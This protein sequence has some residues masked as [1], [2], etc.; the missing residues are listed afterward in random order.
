MTK[1]ICKR[2][3]TKPSGR[4]V[5]EWR[6]DQLHNSRSSL[7][8]DVDEYIVLKN[9]KLLLCNKLLAKWGMVF[10]ATFNTISV[11]SSALLTEK[12]TDKLHVAGKLY[13]IML[14]WVHIAWA[15]TCKCSDPR[16][17]QFGILPIRACIVHGIKIS[18]VC[19]CGGGRVLSHSK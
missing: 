5:C 18:R 9:V 19:M 12:T 3:D 2:G 14:Y 17:Q 1:G 8:R 10:N 16:K 11:I 4:S 15:T 7:G 13:H 6:T